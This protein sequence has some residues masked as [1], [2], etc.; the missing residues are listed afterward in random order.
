VVAAKRARTMVIPPQ[1]LKS[2]LAMQM[3]PFLS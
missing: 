3:P 1:G 2:F